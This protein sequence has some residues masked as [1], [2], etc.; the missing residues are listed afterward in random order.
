[1]DKKKNEFGAIIKKHENSNAG[2]ID[3]P[4]DVRKRISGRSRLIGKALIEGVSWAGSLVK[5]SGDNQYRQTP[6][7]S[8]PRSFQAYN[9]NVKCT[10]AGGAKN[11][12][13]Q[14]QIHFRSSC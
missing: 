7:S 4:F 1:M 2:F 12:Q 13:P 3:Y 9:F 11:S 14:R 5:M 6:H 8:T 10:A